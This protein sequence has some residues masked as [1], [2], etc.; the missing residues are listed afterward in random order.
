MNFGRPTMLTSL[1]SLVV[2]PPVE[3]DPEACEDMKMQ[4]QSENVRLSIILERILSNVYQPWQSTVF[5]D[6]HP[7]AQ[8]DMA[9]QS[10][11]TFVDLDGRL[12]AF[13]RSVPEFLAWKAV[14]AMQF[15]TEDAGKLFVMQRN[16]LHAR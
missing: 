5:H 3:F 10:M 8:P 16:I 4:F 2:P 13:E 15:R 1:S 11:D 7:A 14:A 6:H 12:S 9:C